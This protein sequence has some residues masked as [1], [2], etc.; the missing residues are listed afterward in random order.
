MWAKYQFHNLWR[1]PNQQLCALFGT[2]WFIVHPYSSL[3]S[4]FVVTGMIRIRGSY[5]GFKL[6]LHNKSEIC[7]TVFLNSPLL[8]TELCKWLIQNIPPTEV[9][10]YICLF[11]RGNFND[12]TH[13][14]NI[15][16]IIVIIVAIISLCLL[17]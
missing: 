16:G 13:S 1:C 8:I 3:L 10:T 2:T 11:G 5:S 7:I 6:H 9:F 12:L 14:F 15:F 17:V 4:I